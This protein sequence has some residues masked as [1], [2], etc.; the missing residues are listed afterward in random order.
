MRL[1]GLRGAEEKLPR[2][3]EKPLSGFGEDATGFREAL[4][5]V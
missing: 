3:F 5:G 2:G 4:S 1:A